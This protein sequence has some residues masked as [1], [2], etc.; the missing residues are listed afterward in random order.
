MSTPLA[1]EFSQ[2]PWQ[3]CFVERL[4]GDPNKANFTR[5]VRAACYSEVSPTPVRNPQLL[6]WSDKLA[7]ELGIARPTL[8]SNWGNQSLKI[9]AG[10]EVLPQ[11]RPYAARY[12]GHQFGNWAGQLGDGRAILLGEVVTPGKGRMEFQ[13]KGAGPT[14]YS[15]RADG[16]AVLRS[17]IR[18]FLCSE[19]M[20]FLGVPTT[21][22]L[23]LVSTGDE[24]VRDL[25]YDG[26]PK[27][28]PGAIVCRVSPSFLR[29]GNFEILTNQ[30]ELPLLKELTQF[31]IR[32][33]YP[34]LDPNAPDVYGQLLDE[35]ARRT[36]RMVAHWMRVG[37]VHG[38]MN[39][40]NMSVLGLTIDY[41]P[42]GWLEPYDPHWTP[43]TTDAQGRR[44][45]FG[46]QPGI[47]QWN[48][49]R[50]CEA[51]HPLIQNEARLH[52]TLAIYKETFQKSYSQMLSGKLGLTSIK[53]EEDQ[54]LV[55]DL[56]QLLQSAET[57]FTIFFRALCDFSHENG[58]FLPLISPAFYDRAS[59]TRENVEAWTHWSQRYA[60]RLKQDGKSLH[61]RSAEMK[62]TN[63]KYVPRNYLAQNAIMAA[64][65]GDLSVLE[66]LMRVLENPYSEQ[67][68]EEDL[69]A[70]R[71]EWARHAPGCSA[72][73]CSS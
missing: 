73:S 30:E 71:P 52:E 63:P 35:I 22:A 14:P 38:V 33:Q 43:N 44:Y 1:I 26:N 61:S 15:R 31:L 54:K 10:N 58:A 16:R 13:L 47:A 19:A 17:S 28:E 7:N 59:M 6:A 50:L 70:M 60:A 66:R 40:D 37:F 20:H 34:E 32:D 57:D 29:F 25:F 62:K 42:Y 55:Q 67:A 11:M 36:A 21:R 2:L 64:E 41:G 51:F 68:G 65:K 23:S 48:L 56:F 49:A 9:L 4:P 45:C 8:P 46:N 53:S 27:P 18:E 69:A 5:P 12:G 3:S 24:V 39:T 72:L